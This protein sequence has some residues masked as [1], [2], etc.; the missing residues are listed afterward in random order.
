MNGIRA[1][2]KEAPQS[3]LS[4]SCTC[5]H[6]EKVAVYEPGSRP[7]PDINVTTRAP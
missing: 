2:V 5:G 1:L 6:R 4:P 3:P 7:S